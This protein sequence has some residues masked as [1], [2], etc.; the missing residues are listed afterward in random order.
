MS[1]MQGSAPPYGQHTNYPGVAHARPV[2]SPRRDLLLRMTCIGILV[3]LLPGAA[4]NLRLLIR[5]LSAGA[6]AG[7][8][9]AKIPNQSYANI[10]GAHFTFTNQSQRQVYS[11]VAG[12]LTDIATKRSLKT[13]VVCTG[14]MAPYSTVTVDAHFPGAI[15][16]VCSDARGNLSWDGCTFETE[17][18][19]E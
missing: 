2:P 11:C 14:A 6:I 17:Y 16:D 5:D 1:D 4:Q 18:V 8:Q 9:E 7:P 13:Q 19:S 15:D 3:V 10:S 12:V